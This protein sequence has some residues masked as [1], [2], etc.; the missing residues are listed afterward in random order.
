MT[1]VYHAWRVS[2]AI[3]LGSMNSWN[4]HCNT[5]ARLSMSI[6]PS[7][8]MSGSFLHPSAYIYIRLRFFRASLYVCMFVRT[9]YVMPCHRCCPEQ[10]QLIFNQP[11]QRTQA[12]LAEN[13]HERDTF[14][15][16]ADVF[17]L[18]KHKLNSL[19]NLHSIAG[20]AVS[21]SVLGRVADRSKRM[22]KDTRKKIFPNNVTGPTGIGRI[23]RLWG[24]RICA[25]VTVVFCL[26]VSVLC[27]L[28]V[29]SVY[30]YVCICGG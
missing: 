30:V 17:A 9:Y 19:N 28:S 21:R 2:L 5:L 6:R 16:A 11:T 27:L 14:S 20:S 12:I 23:M 7:V 1:Y 24:L 13:Q 26:C 29:M 8:R 22:H 4:S 10:F 18:Y 3:I 25:V 15:R